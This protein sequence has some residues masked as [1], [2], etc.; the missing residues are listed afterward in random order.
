MR[1]ARKSSRNSPSSNAG[2]KRASLSD[3][4]MY[5]LNWVC[6]CKRGAPLVEKA[7]MTRRRIWT[8]ASVVTGANGVVAERLEIA[9]EDGWIAATGGGIVS[10]MRSTRALDGGR[11]FH[12]GDKIRLWAGHHYGNH[13]A[14]HR[15]RHGARALGL[16][17]EIGVI[18]P[19][20]SADLAIWRAQSVAQL[21][22]RI[23]INPLHCRV[24]KGNVTHG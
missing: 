15:F 14:A 7:R 8:N 4:V 24:F 23:G 17:H 10:S 16:Q 22:N 18:A 12:P 11:G 6:R 3:F 19:G 13:H 5:I 2:Y 9:V 20:H 21:V 1:F